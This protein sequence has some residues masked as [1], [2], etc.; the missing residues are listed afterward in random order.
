M[1]FQPTALM[2]A[3]LAIAATAAGAAD[4]P[5]SRTAQT[6]PGNDFAARI[7]AA[8]NRERAL[9]RAAPL[10]WDPAL[11]AAAAAYG[12]TLER[13]GQ[14]EHS[15]RAGR[16][17]QSENLWMG[18]A[19]RYAPEQMVGSWASEKA[20][21]RPGVFPDVSITGDWLDVSHYTQMIWP[22]TTSVGCALQRGRRADFLICRYAPKG[23]QDGRR[24]P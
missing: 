23:N 2:A 20:R 19:G 13:L 1:R 22:T 6:R 14:L 7:L 8:H 21:F 18:S 4:M 5:G 10:R 16:P 24:V 15:P 12:P 3:A 17:G 11:A 9:V